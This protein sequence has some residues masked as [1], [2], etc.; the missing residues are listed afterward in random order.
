MQEKDA[1]IRIRYLGINLTKE[2]KDKL[3]M[4]IPIKEIEEWTNKWQGILCSWI[5]R[6]HIIKMAIPPKAI[7]R[8]SEIPIKIPMVFFT[9]IEQLIL[10][11]VWNHRI[12]QIANAVL[13]KN[14]AGCI[15]LLIQNI[16]QSYSNQNSMILI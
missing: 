8:F 10:K 14:K 13:K 3:K 9:E 4:M 1:R 11:L 16:L 7:Y 15:T 5:G 6:I 2:V 12:P